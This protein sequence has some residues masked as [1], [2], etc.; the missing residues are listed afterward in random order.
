MDGPRLQK[1]RRASEAARYFDL[2]IDI[3]KKNTGTDPRASRELLHDRHGQALALQYSGIFDHDPEAL[4]KSKKLYRELVGELD[5]MLDDPRTICPSDS[6]QVTPAI[7]QDIVI[8]KMNSL[9][10]EADGYLFGT[11]HEFTV[12]ADH[13]AKALDFLHQQGLDRSIESVTVANLLYKQTMALTFAGDTSAAAEA[14]TKADAIFDGLQQENGPLNF[15]QAVADSAFQVKQHNQQ[16]DTVRR[17]FEDLFH[18]KLATQDDQREVHL[19]RDDR[20]QFDLLAEM[21][22]PNLFQQVSNSVLAVK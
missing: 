20:L 21:I 15:V 17:R 10:R 19:L 5:R 9:E 6:D 11:P 3:R 18:Q 22:E 1:Q 4:Q 13:Y 7:V 8:R 2:A 12:A 14:H 16:I